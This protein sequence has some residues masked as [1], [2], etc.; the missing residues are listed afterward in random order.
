[1][2]VVVILG[3]VPVEVFGEQFGEDPEQ[4]GLVIGER[5]VE[6]EDDGRVVSSRHCVSTSWA[7]CG[8][9]GDGTAQ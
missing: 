9:G 7:D 1:M 2:T 6:I 5:A 3:Q 8:A 4:D